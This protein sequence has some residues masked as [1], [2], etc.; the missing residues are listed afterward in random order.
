MYAI[1]YFANKDTEIRFV[2]R[3]DIGGHAVWIAETLEAAGKKAFIIEKKLK[4][5][6]RVVSLE[7]VHGR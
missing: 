5:E 3:E 1:I 6:A 4:V 7:S 2:E